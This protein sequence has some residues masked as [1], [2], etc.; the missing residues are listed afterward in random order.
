M[1][2]NWNEGGRQDWGREIE[3]IEFRFLIIWIISRLNI[4]YIWLPSKM[5]ESRFQFKNKKVWTITICLMSEEGGRS[6]FQAVVLVP[7]L[8]QTF[9]YYKAN[10]W[11]HWCFIDTC[12]ELIAPDFI[13]EV[14]RL[15]SWKSQTFRTSWKIMDKR[16]RD[17][18]LELYLSDIECNCWTQGS[19]FLNI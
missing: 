12:F 4:L 13:L 3:K 16:E 18:P 5:V 10:L 8:A 2:Q 1:S 11:F 7:A 15:S 6:G 17:K 9:I 19:P 14:F